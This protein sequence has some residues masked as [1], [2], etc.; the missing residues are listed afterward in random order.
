MDQKRKIKVKVEE[1]KE[2]KKGSI[3]YEPPTYNAIP[4]KE[5]LRKQYSLYHLKYGRGERKVGMTLQEP[6]LRYHN[7][8][9][10]HTLNEETFFAY[11]VSF[12]VARGIE[13]LMIDILREFNDYFEHSDNSPGGQSATQTRYLIYLTRPKVDDDQCPVCEAVWLHLKDDRQAHMDVEHPNF[14]WMRQQLEELQEQEKLD[15]INRDYMQWP[16]RG[17]VSYTQSDGPSTS[18]RSKK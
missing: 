4:S 10:Y 12:D 2:K 5:S 17:V 15:E 14:E 9:C 11:A 6:A 7:T 13:L 3:K 8:S 16:S 1:P 18:K